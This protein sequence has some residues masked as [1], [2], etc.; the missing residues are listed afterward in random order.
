MADFKVGDVVLLRSGG[1]KMTIT[2]LPSQHFSGILCEWFD[3]TG[4][5]AQ[6]RFPA[7]SLKKVRQIDLD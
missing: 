4:V 5:P 2:S 6:A 1:P 7:E 3:R